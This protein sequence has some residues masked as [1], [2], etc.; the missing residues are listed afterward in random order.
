MAA[1]PIRVRAID[2]G[3][4]EEDPEVGPRLMRPAQFDD[5]GK[6]TR[7]ADEFN[8]VEKKG[9]RRVRV[10]VTDS[11][12]QP[13]IDKRTGKPKTELTDEMEEHVFTPEEQFSAKWMERVDRPSTAK[14]VSRDPVAASRRSRQPAG[15]QRN[16]PHAQEARE[17]VEA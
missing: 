4:Y 14:P 12:G 8:L 5:K 16:N 6:L 17:K 13:V 2:T 3:Y 10:P 15:R 1:K 7:E 9:L 11:N